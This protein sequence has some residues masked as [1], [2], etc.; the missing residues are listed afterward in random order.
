[1]IQLLEAHVRLL[2]TATEER[3]SQFVR[4]VEQTPAYELTYSELPE[5]MSAIKDLLANHP[6][7]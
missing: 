1:M 3:L 2:G 5:A 7:P 4:F 6:H